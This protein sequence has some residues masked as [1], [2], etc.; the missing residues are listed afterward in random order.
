VRF[1]GQTSY[2]EGSAR[3]PVDASG[4]FTWQRKTGK[5]IYIYVQTEDASLRSNRVIIRQ[6]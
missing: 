4:A 1:P 2:A 5:V 3:V 6:E